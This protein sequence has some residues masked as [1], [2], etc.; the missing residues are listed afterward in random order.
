VLVGR[1][2]ECAQLRRILADTSTGRRQV[3]ALRG[4]PGIGKTRLLEFAV[5]A[6]E[7]FRVV[8]M[9]G[10][11]AEREIP[12]AG[13]SLLVGPLLGD[14]D[15]SEVQLAALE[16]ALNLGSAVHGE[17][18]AVAAA[19]LAVLAAA[20]D[21][22]PLLL[23]VDDV[24][25]IDLP[26]LEALFFALRRMHA[27][28]LAVVLTARPD[29]DVPPAVEQWLE[30][31]TQIHLGG[32]DLDDARRLTAHR[33]VLPV[34][35]WSA[36]GGNPL[37]LLETT[38]PDGAV[39]LDEPI[40]LSARLLR[41][42]GRKLVG[43]PDPTREALLLVAVAGPSEEVL[44][45]TLHHRG[46][47]R[48][49][50]EPAEGAGLVV[51]EQGIVRFGHPLVCSAVYHSASPAVRR[52]AHK[53]MA[54]AYDGRTAPGAAERQAFHLAAATAGPDDVVA[55]LIADAAK[56]AAGRHSHTTAAVLFEK[57]ALLSTPGSART[58]R[59]IDAA[60][61]G[62]AAGT[63][64][65]VGPLLD[66][67]VAETDDDDLRTT[68]MHLQS[69]VQMWSGHPAQARDQLLDLADRIED[70]H[71]EWSA[72]MRSQAATVSIAMGEQRLAR[73]MAGRAEELTTHLPDQHAL[74]VLLVQ[75]LTLAINGEVAPA[76]AL[77]ERCAPY[78]PGYDP[79]SIDHLLVLAALAYTSLGDVATG[80]RWL[81]ASVRRIRSAQA[82]GLLPFQLSWLAFVCWLDGDWVA[83]L[84]HGHAAV[85]V[86][87][88]TGW[89][90]ELPNCLV[91]LATVEAALG[92]ETDVRGHLTEAARLG[93]QQSEGRLF[94]AHA[95]RVTG[96]LELGAGR[97]VEAAEALRAAGEF[98]RAAR[99][100]DPVVFS[101]AA[102]L[103]E[104]LVR[105]GRP[106]QA[107]GAYRSARQESE[108]T[109]RPAALA[110]AARCRGLLA[111]STDEVRQAFDEALRR[112]DEVGLPFERARTQL[113][114]GE[115][116]RRR[117][118]R[119]PA[120]EQLGAA[121]ATFVGLGATPWV[122]RAEAELQATGLTARAREP[123]TTEQLTP[124]ELQ[125]AFTVAEG[126]SNAAAAARLFVTPKTVEFHL[127]N[128]YRKLGIHS[129]AELVR[130]MAAGPPQQR[131]GPDPLTTDDAG[132]ATAGR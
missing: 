34:T 69:R 107:A 1:D 101:W 14:T 70:R 22:Q 118:L 122:R 35:V 78:L 96:L 21:A 117:R 112:H 108:R 19:T 86:A 116:L 18:M 46:L 13:L 89:F 104:A 99:M 58:Q 93:A 42:Y 80:R 29:G 127:S 48:A 51:I 113:C 38:A 81:E 120:R 125:V 3:V 82:V 92:H 68:A 6:A 102:D 106:D 25:A 111:D 28:R 115:V 17:R 126:L 39:F 129:R 41:A 84:A 87:K 60:L 98:A 27:E 94:A 36:S 59:M 109:G 132:A 8:R 62:Q 55:A 73:G 54:A 15:L 90:T 2:G 37:A 45:D 9:Q 110:A 61:A 32:L 44:D 30:P 57:A 95:A 40:Q 123:G 56:A 119:G 72:V 16:G 121:L 64:D 49:D 23:A 76:R 71:R 33:G 26:T 83:A 53:A 12:F 74:P 66:R 31:V 52:T 43:L 47:S 7:G 63:L 4:D 77:L 67:A 100:G 88:E 20:A 75:A 105:S 79:L 114:Y 65:I 131:T 10:H 50:L 130:R 128:I 124:Q 85:A 91:A 11:E 5:A 24:H 97:P 103:V